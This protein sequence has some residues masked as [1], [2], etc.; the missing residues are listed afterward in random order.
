[1]TFIAL[2]DDDFFLQGHQD[3]DPLALEKREIRRK[4][5]QTHADAEEQDSETLEVSSEKLRQLQ[6]GDES[7]CR[8]RIIA[9]GTPSAAAGENIYRRDGLIYRRY[10]P[11]GADSDSS[12]E[13]LVLPTLLRPAVMKLAH[14][15]PMAGHLGKRKTRDRILRRFYP[16][17]FRDVEDHCRRCPQCQNHQDDE[18]PKHP[19]IATNYGGAAPEDCDGHLLTSTPQQLRSQVHS[20]SFVTMPLVTQ[21]LFHYAPLRQTRSPRSYSPSSHA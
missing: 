19:G 21:R 5:R 18:S 2:F 8:L 9:D 3:P 7:L 6:E 13:Q 16:G 12:I 4:H 14:D 20:L 11:P 15:I 17:I 1:M 10:D